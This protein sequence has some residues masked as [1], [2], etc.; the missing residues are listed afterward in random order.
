MAVH[1]KQIRTVNYANSLMSMLSHHLTLPLPSYSTFSFCQSSCWKSPT[2]SQVNLK[3][4]GYNS[5][6]IRW[7]IS[8]FPMIRCIC[9]TSSTKKFR[10]ASIENMDPEGAELGNSI[11]IFLFF[12]RQQNYE[13]K[14]QLKALEKNQK[15]IKSKYKNS[16]IHSGICSFFKGASR[17]A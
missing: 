16:K 3:E 12:Y 2:L 4:K 13:N 17:S 7:E 6:K 5:A 11:T 14:W 9:G 8:M 1:K 15:S 10:R